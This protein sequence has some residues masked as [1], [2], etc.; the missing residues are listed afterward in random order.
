MLVRRI[1]VMLP[2]VAPAEARQHWP[3]YASY[4]TFYEARG[5]YTMANT[6]NQW[7]SDTLAA[8]GVRTGRW[9]PFA[10][11]VMKWVEE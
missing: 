4:D 1:E 6:C 8:A 3:G 9:T 11:G 2:P 7:T 10:G 5:R